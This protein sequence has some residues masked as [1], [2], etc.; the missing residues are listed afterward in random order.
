MKIQS[1][2]INQMNSRNDRRFFRVVL[3]L[4]LIACSFSHLDAM[5]WAQGS[6]ADLR[7]SSV[8]VNREIPG[9][10]RL[11]TSLSN[12]K[13]SPL[14]IY[15]QGL[16]VARVGREA[17]ESIIRSF[18]ES[19]YVVLTLDYAGA[20]EA[21]P[22]RLN[23]DVYQLRGDIFKKRF[24]QDLPFDRNHIFILPAGYRLRRDVPFYQDGNRTLAMDVSYPADPE[25]PV[26]TII[27]YSC[28]NQE[29]MGLFSLAF[30][31]DTL[32]EGAM[33]S[34]F[35][36][37]MADHPVAAPYKGLD[38]M[39][40]CLY[41]LKSSVRVLRGLSDQLPLNGRIA[42]LG[43]S[44]GS[45]MALMLASTSGLEGFD[46]QGFASDVSSDVQAAVVL[47][48]RF[49]YTD[50]LPTDHMIPRYDKAWGPRDTHFDVWQRHSAAHY[51]SANTPPLFLSINRTEDEDAL[52][53]MKT[54]VE[55]VK[56]LGISHQYLPET[57]PRGHKMPL[58]PNIIS[59]LYGFLHDAM[60]K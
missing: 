9:D 12:T 2:R 20:R 59:D 47:S 40:D 44:R 38:P 11:P 16:A 37:A 46:G 52:H 56:S 15:L 41:K 49:D 54:L 6:D 22:P 27:E 50:I 24:L 43:F 48:G 25:S 23:L 34:G 57:E 14:V 21:C 26:P 18:Q 30:C 35:A 28:D 39:P 13:E 60:S 32:L 5:A 4:W 33:A 45:G 1:H 10:L 51:L 19:G 36:T 42:S 29:R 7:W 3:G 55:Q 17:D 58:D 53:Q 31:S 8:A